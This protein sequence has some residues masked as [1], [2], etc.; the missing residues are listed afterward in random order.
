MEDNCIYGSLLDDRDDK[1]YKTIKI[2]TQEW[3]AENLNYEIPR[4]SGTS[5]WSTC[6][7]GSAD[8]CAKY[9]RYYTWTAAIDSIFLHDSL[10]LQC[11]CGKACPNLKNLKI[12]GACPKNWHLPS[13][14]EWQTLAK[15]IGSQ[16]AGKL[17]KSIWENWSGEDSFGFSVLPSGIVYNASVTDIGT[18]AYFWTATDNAD[19]AAM[20]AIFFDNRDDITISISFKEV[21]NALSVRCIKD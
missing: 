14:K 13:Q 19:Y 21:S 1:I 12:K 7:K 18:Q 9:G 4:K 10:S 16:N 8:S 20:S 17:L 5:I 15:F 6:Y 3:M 11:G 2:G